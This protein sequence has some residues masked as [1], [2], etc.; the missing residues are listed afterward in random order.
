MW[1]KSTPASRSV[2]HERVGAVDVLVD[3]ARRRGVVARGLER[4]VGHRVDGVR[5][6]QLVD[7]QR[8]GVGSFLV[9]VDAHSGRWTRAPAAASFSQRSPEKIRWKD[10]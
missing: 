6:D 2:V 4:G 9:D 8:V 5:A 7:V 10:S 3:G 1:S